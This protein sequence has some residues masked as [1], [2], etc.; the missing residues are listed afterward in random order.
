MTRGATFPEPSPRW[1]PGPG[2]GRTG[3]ERGGSLGT[4]LLGLRRRGPAA[5]GRGPAG[6]GSARPPPP[7]EGRPRGARPRARFP[8]GRRRA[9]S[10]FCLLRRSPTKGQAG[11]GGGGGGGGAAGAS[12]SR[13]KL[14]SR[15]SSEEGSGQPQPAAGFLP[16]PLGAPQRAV[17][18]FSRVVS[19][20]GK[21]SSVWPTWCRRARSRF[22]LG[23]FCFCFWR[24]YRAGRLHKLGAF[25]FN[26]V[27]K[28]KIFFFFLSDLSGPSHFL[29]K[30][31]CSTEL[32]LA[33]SPAII[34]TQTRPEE[35]GPLGTRRRRRRLAGRRRGPAGPGAGIDV[36]LD[37]YR[38]LEVLKRGFN[39]VFGLN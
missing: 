19:A 30:A 13:T 3:A 22:A 9:P 7:G 26:R 16:K 36:E 17:P 12:R 23:L 11:G 37:H 38:K 20:D 5:E 21:L 25:S 15:L 35:R 28:K 31:R 33:H 2:R 8:G 1:P 27:S 10:L 39:T 18:P 29:F 6:S 24:N 4:K 14:W 32:T 34:E